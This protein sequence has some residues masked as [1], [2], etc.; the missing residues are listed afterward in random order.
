MD[1][2]DA[3]RRTV[4]KTLGVAAGVGALATPAAGHDGG[5]I[6]HLSKVWAATYQYMDSARAYEHGYVVPGP[7]GLGPLEDV[8]E[9]GHAVC[10]MGYHFVNRDL[11]GS[12]D[13]R[14]PQVLAYGVDGDGELTLGA[15]E[16][17]VPK[18]GPHETDPPDL[19]GHDGGREV[20]AEDSP[21]EGVWSLHAWVH[22]PNPD[23]MFAAFNPRDEFHPEG[24]TDPRE[25]HEE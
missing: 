6:G 11:I 1:L 2:P 19:F 21:Q 5:L 24:C 22:A 9:M 15:V 25:A 13:P 18:A 14:K 23:G 10:G 8:Q 12:T 3:T 7:D 20:W 16:Y 17:V 4:L